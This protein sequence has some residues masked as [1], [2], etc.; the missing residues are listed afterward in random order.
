MLTRVGIVATPEVMPHAVWVPKANRKEFSFFTT[1][2]TFD[3][4]EPSIVL[5]S[6]FATADTARGRG[7]FN[8]GSY[9]NPLFDQVLDK[10]LT[11]MDRDGRERLL[12]QATDIA[13]RDHVM[14][15]LHHQFNIE[16]MTSASATSHAMTDTSCLLISRHRNRTRDYR[17]IFPLH[18][19]RQRCYRLTTCRGR[20][21]SAA[22]SAQRATSSSSIRPC[23]T[24]SRAAATIAVDIGRFVGIALQDRRARIAGRRPF[25]CRLGERNV[26]ALEP[27]LRSMPVA[28]RAGVPAGIG[29]ERRRAPSAPAR[30][31]RRCRRRSTAGTS[32][33]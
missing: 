2:W 28:A 10:A 4:P 22:A 19:D 31:Q 15:P 30:R 32:T 21:Q 26:A 5:I 27:P 23:A 18:N 14:L 7:I 24:S 8:R 9:S 1:F 12:I 11:T 25:R 13:F 20:P 17:V 29:A 3:T 6:Q 33:V 16:A